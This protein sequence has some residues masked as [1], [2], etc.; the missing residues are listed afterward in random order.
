MPENMRHVCVSMVLLAI[1]LLLT[2][3]RDKG[4]R[5]EEGFYWGLKAGATYSITDGLKN[6]LIDPIY[7]ADSYETIDDYRIGPTV[8]L[9]ID[10]RHSYDSYLVGR[11][12]F[13]YTSMGGM[14]QYTDIDGLEYDLTMGYDY[15]TVAPLLKLNVPPDWPYVLAGIQFGINVASNNIRYT[16]NDDANVDLQVQQSLRDVLKGRSN[17]GLTF[18]L[19]FEL[20]RSGLALE[21]RYTLGLTDVIET[22]PNGFLFIETPNKTS[23]FQVTLGMPVPF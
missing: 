9:F 20:T 22:Q 14:F 11:L 23:F 17:T 13:G 15:I 4:A 2:A 12:E 21:G 16:S 10:Y 7:P 3:Q 18:G 6:T 1:P 8:S 5:F 19:G